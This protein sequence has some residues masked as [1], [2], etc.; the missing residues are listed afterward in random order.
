MTCCSQNAALFPLHPSSTLTGT[1]SGYPP[2]LP[3]RLPPSPIRVQHGKKQGVG[4]HTWASG[5]T[6]VGGNYGNGVGWGVG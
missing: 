3:A 5:A 6:Y 2:P 1:P 4:K